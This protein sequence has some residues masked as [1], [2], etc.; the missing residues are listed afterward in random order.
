MKTLIWRLN[1]RNLFL[2][3]LI[4]TYLLG[5]TLAIYLTQNGL[6]FRYNFSYYSLF[7]DLA[8]AVISFT[9]SYWFFKE[10]IIPK[11]TILSRTVNSNSN[12][13]LYYTGLILCFIGSLALLVYIAYNG[14]SFR[15]ETY[16]NR[17]YNSLGIGIVTKLFIMFPLGFTLILCSQK[18]KIN[19][20]RHGGI[21]FLY[22]LL[23]TLATG[24][25]RQIMLIGIISF[26]LIAYLL[27]SI[28]KIEIQF[29]AF[30]SVCVIALIGALRNTGFDRH[31]TITAEQYVYAIIDSFAPFDSYLK[32]KDYVDAH[33]APGIAVFANQFL[34]Y[35]PRA[36]WN[37]K[38][39]LVL[40]SGNFFTQSV[41]DYSRNVTISPTILGEFY[42][43]G[44]QTG[45]VIGCIFTGLILS[46]FDTLFSPKK[47][48]IGVGLFIFFFFAPFGL[49]REGLAVYI[50]TLL[51]VLSIV[52]ICLTIV[53]LKVGRP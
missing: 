43:I 28:S 38:P 32:I 13:E 7:F 39:M 34:S 30:L 11:S 40:N 31:V 14:L 3:Y 48:T 36:L 44:G 2:F 22:G 20:Y 25:Y 15:W 1:Q 23:L 47:T 46:I 53:K 16:E 17:Y 19:K 33:G 45:I 10:L 21:V 37:D 42:L 50:T 51:W 49:V 35:I 29:T 5:P 4:V 12:N 52:F 27:K 24:G 9:T 8:M 26:L 6:M 41:L 18:L